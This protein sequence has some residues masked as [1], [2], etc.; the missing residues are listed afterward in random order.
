MNSV[1]FSAISVQPLTVLVDGSFKVEEFPKKMA[2]SSAQN[3]RHKSF[4]LRKLTISSAS[5]LNIWSHSFL[6]CLLISSTLSLM[7]SSTAPFGRPS[8]SLENCFILPLCLSL[9]LVH[10]LILPHYANCCSLCCSPRQNTRR[11]SLSM[12]VSRKKWTVP[13]LTGVYI[14]LWVPRN[15]DSTFFRCLFVDSLRRFSVHC[16]FILSKPVF[17]KFKNSFT[18]GYILLRIEALVSAIIL[19]LQI[20]LIER[21]GRIIYSDSWVVCLFISPLIPLRPLVCVRPSSKIPSFSHYACRISL[22]LC[23]CSL[24]L[25]HTLPQQASGIVRVPRNLDPPLYH[26]PVLVESLSVSD[27][28]MI[29]VSN[30]FELLVIY[31]LPWMGWRWRVRSFFKQITKF[32][33]LWLDD[34]D[35]VSL[36]ECKLSYTYWFLSILIRQYIGVATVSAK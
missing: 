1:C 32:L 27:P 14:I 3:S 12:L 25:T 9:F 11:R 33:P 22:S 29:L 28:T 21:S 17:H 26:C 5:V 4:F 6:F 18:N 35:N 19:S 8:A 16:L 23:W 20:E 13:Q 30:Q 34:W 2:I 24:S 15:L 36:R 31:S 10:S 7:L